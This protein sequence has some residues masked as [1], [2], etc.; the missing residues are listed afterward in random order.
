MAVGFTAAADRPEREAERHLEAVEP[1]KERDEPIE[2]TQRPGGDVATP[3]EACRDEPSERSDR[4]Y[5]PKRLDRESGLHEQAPE[6]VFPVSAVVSELAI[7]RTVEERMS[8]HK[9]Q[10][11]P[12]G[13]ELLAEATQ[14][15]EVVRDVL[16]NVEADDRVETVGDQ[17]GLES[18]RLGFDDPNVRRVR[19]AATQH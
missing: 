2:E 3:E 9:E 10:K 18:V 17:A 15:F 6:R 11:A 13:R 5:V 7:D 16:E 19:E 14:R 12:F 8:G 1:P 4:V